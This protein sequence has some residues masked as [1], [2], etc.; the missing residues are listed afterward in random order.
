MAHLIITKFWSSQEA[1]N[2]RE[3][4]EALFQKKDYSKAQTIALP[5][6]T[7]NPVWIVDL[8]RA[9]GAVQSSS[10]A[11]RLIETKSVLIDG[12]P[13]SEFKVSIVWKSGMII[14]V[15]KHRIYRL[16]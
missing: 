2:A 12:E 4:F 14:K 1:D 13:V 11:K 5:S 7:S 3:N 15:G 16:D 8:L 10:E 6:G 9:I